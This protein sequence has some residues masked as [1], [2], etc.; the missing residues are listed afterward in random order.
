MDETNETLSL[1][2]FLPERVRLIEDL[3]HSELNLT[4]PTRFQRR[5]ERSTQ[6]QRW[7]PMML[8]PVAFWRSHSRNQDAS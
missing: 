2:G 7:S 5:Q 6:F 4:P 3:L 1:T 8:S